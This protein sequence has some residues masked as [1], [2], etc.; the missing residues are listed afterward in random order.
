[1]KLLKRPKMKWR[2]RGAKNVGGILYPETFEV[3]RR[4]ADRIVRG[5]L[6]K[7]EQPLCQ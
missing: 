4:G 7:Q 1:M 6:S 5:E 2:R 3:L